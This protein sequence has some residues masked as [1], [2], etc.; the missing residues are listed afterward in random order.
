MSLEPS[1]PAL[2]P[3]L[4]QIRDRARAAMLGAALGDALG[5]TVEFLTPCEIRARYGVLR[6]IKGGGWLGLAPGQVTDDTQ[7]MLC[8]ARS[9]AQS[10]WSLEDMA[11]KFVAWMKSKPID[12]GNTCRRGIRR[13]MLEG[14]LAGP[15]NEGDAGNGAAMR[16]APVAIASLGDIDLLERRAIEQA[17]ITHH[18]HH[19][20]AGCL[21][22]GRLLQ[23]ACSGR[24]RDHLL[25]ETES[26]LIRHPAF[27]FVPYR[28]LSTTYIV[29]TMQTVL[30]YFF[31]S[32]SFEECLVGTVNQ[33]GDADTTG[34]IAG[35]IAGALYGTEQL[36]RRWLKKLDPSLIAE[37]TQLSDQIVDFSPLA[38]AARENGSD[39][40]QSVERA[41]Q[42]QDLRDRRAS[43]RADGEIAWFRLPTSKRVG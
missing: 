14:T 39:R 25:W 13:F 4:A 24:D 3:N 11:T 27:H 19:S 12:I 32:R 18:H 9:I 35:A 16:M 28:G 10:G 42:D 26:F 2:P 6:D 1:T 17:H 7:M 37:L 23:L 34:A 5:A 29:D 38:L 41:Q 36:P 31:G 40:A 30:H 8:V 15:P 22:V 33:G 20:D 21:L 43:S